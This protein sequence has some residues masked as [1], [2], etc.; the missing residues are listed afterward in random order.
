MSGPSDK[1]WSLSRYPLQVPDPAQLGS[2]GFRTSPGTERN[3]K[4]GCPHH[5]ASD[6][7][8]R[9]LPVPNRTGRD[10]S[11]RTAAAGWVTDNLS[12]GAPEDSRTLQ[13]LAGEQPR[14]FRTREPHPVRKPAWVLFV[15]I[16][17]SV[18]T[19]PSVKRPPP[20][21]WSE[22]LASRGILISISG[23]D[24]T[25]KTTVAHNVVSVF[26]ERGFQASYFYGTANPGTNPPT[27]PES[28]LRLS[29]SPFGSGSGGLWGSWT[30]THGPGPPI[31]AFPSSTTCS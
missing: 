25:G 22:R 6:V 8:S 12:A 17:G 9:W 23:I 20:S 29:T 14:R 26:R 19:P 30:D 18:E 24:G 16:L 4:P 11:K 2:R 13:S 15:P 10:F 21:S 5:S 28:R 31:Q 27:G 3:F 1:T 7:S